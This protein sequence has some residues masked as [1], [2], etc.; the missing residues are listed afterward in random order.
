VWLHFFEWKN[1][2][3]R[4]FLC[5]TWWVDESFHCAV[6][7]VEELVVGGAEELV[8]GEVEELVVGEVELLV[9]EAAEDRFRLLVH[10][11]QY[12]HYYDDCY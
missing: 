10:R 8:V 7:E 11:Y 3:P 5:R 2:S 9:G 4:R 6:G 12:R 1:L